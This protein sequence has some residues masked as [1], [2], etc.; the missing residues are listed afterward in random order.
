MPA[1]DVPAGYTTRWNAIICEPASDEPVIA[2]SSGSSLASDS[3]R[4]KYNTSCNTCRISRVKC[5]GGFPCQRCSASSNPSSCAYSVSRRRGKRKASDGPTL[6]DT[7]SQND[8][9]AQPDQ[10][11]IH[12]SFGSMMSNDW[13]GSHG[14]PWSGSDKQANSVGALFIL[15][16]ENMK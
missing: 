6:P 1:S 15:F 10:P 13:I 14:L 5:S 4:R 9:P 7:R 3:T 16:L 12:F 8:T 11:S 2:P